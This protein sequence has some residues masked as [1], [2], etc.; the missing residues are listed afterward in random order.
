MKHAL[1]C[2]ILASLLL[3]AAD[4]SARP[5]A[6]TPARAAKPQLQVST[7][8]PKPGDPVLVTVTGVAGEPSGTGGRV[9]LVFFPVARGW[10]AVFAVPLEDAPARV[11][12][13]A[14]GLTETLTVR[15]HTFAEEAVTVAPELAE[16]PADKRKQLDEDNA[17]VIE[18]VK[19]PAP[20]LFRGRFRL[21]GKGRQTSPFGS[22]R[23]LNGDYRSRHLGLDIGARQGSPVRA[24]QHGK[25]TLVHD[26]FLMGGTVVLTH[27]A[28]IASTYFHLTD[29]AVA[30][31][32]VV[33]PGQV[34]G[35]VGMTGRTTG[36]HIHLGIWV[37]GGFIDPAAFLRLPLA[38][39]RA[40]T[41]PA[42][43]AR[44]KKPAPA[45]RRP[46]RA[47][48]GRARR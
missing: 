37:P 5:R 23:T 47:R 22:W 11:E 21:P 45:R 43:P 4:A 6:R 44:P 16:P 36:P 10:Q 42:A 39:P 35:K 3:V 18:A 33:K 30:A 20:P 38:T 14:G 41:R 48:P 28:G 7:R 15:A 24:V 27:G 34:V 32:D 25:V 1:A 9:P 31:G 8:T 29:I 46:G 13:T 12:V 17:A 40:T 26:G 2:G 19:D